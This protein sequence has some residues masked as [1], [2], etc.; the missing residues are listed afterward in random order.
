MSRA[1]TRLMTSSFDKPCLASSAAKSL[2]K[3]P[4]DG[5]L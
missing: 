3:I 2:P 5:A 1:D 4:V